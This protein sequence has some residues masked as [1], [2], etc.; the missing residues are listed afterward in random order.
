MS[1]E[2]LEK[3]LRALVILDEVHSNNRLGKEAAD[4]IVNLRKQLAAASA[5]RASLHAKL[6]KAR[7]GLRPF[8]NA[9]SD[10]PDPYCDAEHIGDL[11]DFDCWESPAAMSINAS[12]LIHARAILAELS[13]DEAPAQKLLYPHS[14]LEMEK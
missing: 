9:A 5:E 14:K 1:Y 6:A 11:S 4:V 10:L 12:D 8:A 7:E 13:D 2:D 3:R